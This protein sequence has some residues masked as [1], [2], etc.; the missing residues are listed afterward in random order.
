MSV[1]FSPDGC[2]MTYS[3]TS[4]GFSNAPYREAQVRLQLLAGIG[5][6]LTVGLLVGMSTSP[7]VATL[8]GAIA[9]GLVLL[10]GF[11]SK[12]QTDAADR[13]TESAG[14]RLA[15]FGM[16]CAIALLMG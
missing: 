8:L 1:C 11:T 14:W 9:G 4:L 16:A 6:G 12:G 15:G 10:L 3:Q 7:V 2:Y 13:A 5:L